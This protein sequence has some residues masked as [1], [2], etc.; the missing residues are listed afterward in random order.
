MDGIPSGERSMRHLPASAKLAILVV[1]LSIPAAA[2][3]ALPS[4]WLLG[5]QLTLVLLALIGAVA[6][7]RLGQGSGDLDAALEARLVAACRAGDCDEAAQCL[8]QAP[9]DGALAA[10][11]GLLTDVQV[12][13]KSAE[14]VL[15]DVQTQLQALLAQQSVGLAAMEQ[16]EIFRTL[17][18]ELARL[19]AAI[20]GGIAHAVKA[21]EV[22]RESGAH[23][24]HALAATQE[25]GRGAVALSEQSQ[26]MKI[27]FDELT[28]QA[29]QIGS[30]VGSIQDV[31]KRTN[32]LA[33][34][35]AI[36]AARAGEAGRGFA[37]VADEVRELS[38]QANASSLQIARI[39]QA[40]FAKSSEA[41]EGISVSLA[42]I[43]EVMNA[44]GSVA[45][46]IDQV[47][48]GAAIRAEVVKK[49]SEQ[50]RIQLEHCGNLHQQVETA[51]QRVA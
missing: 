21:G 38:D 35:A 15:A 17:D 7:Y 16:E 11:R 19:R 37:V 23:V 4:P 42:S 8:A 14:E 6:G 2:S 50:F 26:A 24:D 9:A 29:R 51:L 10:V 18:D 12:K 44:S 47:K 1:V 36:E 13:R 22:A 20:E 46:S 49:A 41:A 5:L 28:E 43:E 39:T 45:S 33:L 30:I 34:N 31:A 40:L 3:L 27:V 48:A 32:L 25:V